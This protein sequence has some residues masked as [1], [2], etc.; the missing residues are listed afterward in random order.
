MSFYKSLLRAFFAF[1]KKEQSDL[2]ENYAL[3][4]SRQIHELDEEDAEIWWD[5]RVDFW[6]STCGT[7]PDEAFSGYGQAC[8]LNDAYGRF[9]KKPSKKS[10]RQVLECLDVIK[11]GWE[12]GGLSSFYLTLEENFPDLKKQ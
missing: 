10:I 4:I 5:E 9:F 7:I 12:D 3:S 2:V 11:I 1:F 6:R 8:D